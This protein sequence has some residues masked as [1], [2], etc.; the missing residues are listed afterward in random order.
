MTGNTEIKAIMCL[1]KGHTCKA[2]LGVPYG[3]T[4]EGSVSLKDRIIL[5]ADEASMQSPLSS[6][7]GCLQ[8]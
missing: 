8:L 5:A 4:P 7:L 6:N 2:E 3:E 1:L